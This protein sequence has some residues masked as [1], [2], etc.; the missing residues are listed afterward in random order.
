MANELFLFAFAGAGLLWYLLLSLG[1]LHSERSSAPIVVWR[2]ASDTGW[3]D[4]VE[5]AG[6][7]ASTE[8][9]GL[10]ATVR[11]QAQ[12]D[13]IAVQFATVVQPS[14]APDHTWTVLFMS[15]VRERS[16][17]LALAANR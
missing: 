12:S 8:Y 5:L 1:Q 7:S 16:H 11:D 17:D 6:I 4:W 9:S 10:L 15:A 13:A 2:A 14:D 3:S